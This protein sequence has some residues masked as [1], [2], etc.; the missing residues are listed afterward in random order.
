VSQTGLG[1]AGPAQ[2]DLLVH[3]CGRPTGRR[4]TPYV[5]LDIHD[6][7]PAVRLDQILT[8][9][10]L[11][12]FP[13]FGA[14]EDQPTV[15][16]SESPLPHLEHLLQRG[17][18]PWGILFRRQW[19]YDQGGE[20]VA[21]VR[22]RRW[23]R[24]QREDKPWT[25]RLEADPDKG[26]SDWT[27]EREWRIPLSP[28]QPYLKLAPES[29]AGI[30]VGDASWQP[31]SVPSGYNINR[32]TGEIGDGT[33]PFDEPWPN[34]SPLWTSTPKWLWSPSTGLIAPMI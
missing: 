25:V 28:E 31:S 10:Q 21:Y 12:G 7:S 32:L 9:G 13:P 34:P 33:D 11:K 16:F 15:C 3:F 6:A 29:I 8:S 17:W 26:W 22:A 1:W 14:D 23:D 18:K 19:V 24:R 30:L 2:S 20:P 4:H 5:P 27:H